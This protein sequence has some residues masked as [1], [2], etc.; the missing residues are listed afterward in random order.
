M[1]A[2]IV[3]SQ[4]EIE[5]TYNTIKEDAKA[6]SYFIN[7]DTGFTRDLVTGLL[8]N[9]KRYGYPMCPCRLTSGDKLVDADVICPCEYRDADV[10]EFGSCY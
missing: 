3:V 2:E 7:P 5:K 6:G 10:S 8:I 4:E 9:D 1:S